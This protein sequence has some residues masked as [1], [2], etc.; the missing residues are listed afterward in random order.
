MCLIDWDWW[1]NNV[2][3][4]L[5]PITRYHED[6]ENF[7]HPCCSEIVDYLENESTVSGNAFC[8]KNLPDTRLSPLPPSTIDFALRPV[9]SLGGILVA[10]SYLRSENTIFT[11]WIGYSSSIFVSFH[12]HIIIFYLWYIERDSLNEYLN[13]YILFSHLD[14]LNEY[15]N[16]YSI[17]SFGFSKWWSI[18]IVMLLSYD[19]T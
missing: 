16:Y 10:E 2:S 5:L 15:S 18:Q 6:R 3:H 9:R 8:R 19:I 4:V 17:V 11:K 14:S 1:Y 12:A 7:N 13:C